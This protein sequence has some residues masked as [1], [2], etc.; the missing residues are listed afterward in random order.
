MQSKRLLEFDAMRGVAALC[1]V[2]FHYGSSYKW[3]TFHP[4]NSLHYLEQFVQ[5]FFILSGFFILLSFKRIKRSLDFIAGR[6]ARLYPVYWISV[7]TTLI[8]TNTITKPRTDKI[9]DIILNFSMFQEFVGAKNVNIVY[10]T[11]T[12]ELVFYIIILS[13]YK[14]KL[15]KHIEWIC[16]FWLVMIFLNILKAYTSSQTALTIPIYSEASLN[17]NS[18]YFH[19]STVSVSGTLEFLKEFIK[20]KFLLLGGRAELFISGIFLYQIK[21]F[22]FSKYRLGMI[23]FCILIKALDYSP[24]APRYAFLFFVFFVILMCLAIYGKL[25]ALAH[26]SLVFLGT[27]SYSLY[28]THLQV[29]WFLHPLLAPIPNE[30]GI[31]IKVITAIIVASFLTVKV[32]QPAFGMLKSYYKNKFG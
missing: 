15:I 30:L 21:T 31:I 13:L 6:F 27:I 5:L 19:L 9:Y 25:T 18:A 32:E 10:W 11:L 23:I 4:F 24:N 26:Q 22:G 29:Q 2:L 16:T 28:L 7:I 14:L 3:A 1:I 8:I 17:L 20:N 12:L